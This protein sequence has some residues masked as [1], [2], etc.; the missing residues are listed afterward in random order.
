MAGLEFAVYQSELEFVELLQPCLMDAS[1]PVMTASF[2]FPYFF[3]M[4]N[5]HT[6]G[7]PVFCVVQAPVLSA[8]SGSPSTFVCSRFD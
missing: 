5:L 1:I 2:L 6:W 7:K 3:I 8:T 4:P